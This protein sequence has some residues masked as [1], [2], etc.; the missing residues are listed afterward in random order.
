MMFRT[1][2]ALTLFSIFFLIQH[3]QYKFAFF[4]VAL[5][6]GIFPDIGSGFSLFGGTRLVGSSRITSSIHGFF[7]SLTFVLVASALLA[8]YLPIYAL[9]FF[10]GYSLHLFADSFT[11]EGIKPFWPLRYESKGPLKS[12]SSVESMLFVGFCIVDFVLLINFFL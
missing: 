1:H 10:L 2:V 3:V 4:V 9:P 12:G 6:A 5:I 8:I 11:I 7:H